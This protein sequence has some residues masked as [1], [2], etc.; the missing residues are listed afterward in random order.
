MACD[1]VKAIGLVVPDEDVAPVV[2]E[3]KREPVR[4][5]VVAEEQQAA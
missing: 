5:A 1:P 3:D 4:A 2:T